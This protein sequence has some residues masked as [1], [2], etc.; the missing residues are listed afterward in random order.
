MKR[1]NY[2]VV[3]LLLSIFTIFVYNSSKQIDETLTYPEDGYMLATSYMLDDDSKI[4]TINKESEVL[5][6][7]D[8]KATDLSFIAY[9]DKNVVVSGQR[10]N[11]HLIIN[12]NGYIEKVHFWNKENK[13]GTTTIKT[14]GD[15]IFALMNVGYVD[16]LYQN[17]LVI[18]NK[19]GEIL[20]EI[21]LKISGS[22]M[23]I[24]DNYIIITGSEANSEKGTWHGKIIVYD[25]QIRGILNEYVNSDYSEFSDICMYNNDLIF[26]A[27][28]L[29]VDSDCIVRSKLNLEDVSHIYQGKLL[30]G[31]Y[32]RNGIVFAIDNSNLIG[33]NLY[34]P[35][36]LITD[37]NLIDSG[38]Y[39]NSVISNDNL[40]ILMRNQDKLYENKNINIGKILKFNFALNKIDEIDLV[41]PEKLNAD[42]FLILP[43]LIDENI[44]E[45]QNS[46]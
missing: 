16:G 19:K 13:T 9:D 15:N 46:Q 6:S 21:Y 24:V 1:K 26:I 38:Y 41:L 44:K 18:Q 27:K 12:E 34:E 25:M 3:I 22:N 4:I 45:K 31:L 39:S 23:L 2:I 36:K 43:N 40:I 5:D 35:N 7:I 8:I 10:S 30:A 28:K 29:N 17:C 20:D 33:F 14:N 42:S 32:I 37:I 11:D